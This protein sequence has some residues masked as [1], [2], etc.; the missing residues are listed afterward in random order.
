MSS[1]V[2]RFLSIVLVCLLGLAAPS[3]ADDTRSAM[4]DAMVRMMEA[5]GLFGSTGGSFSSGPPGWSN[6]MGMSGWPSGFGAMPAMPGMPGMP[7]AGSVP[8]PS[9]GGTPM[10][11]TTQ[12]GQM[13]QMMERFAPGAAPWGTGP[14]EGI[15][16]GSDDGLLIVQGERYRLYAPLSGS[17]DGD[18]RVKGDRVELSNQR[19]S[20]TQ[21]FE[22]ALDQGRLV[23]R[24]RHGQI[25][26]YRRLVLDGGR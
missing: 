6:P 19:E 20:F 17:I 4:A 2:L 25:Y 23:F 16:E 26:L 13:G 24:D 10:D 18:I 11:P 5:M 21:E 3:P 7:G 8:M 1:L 9:P 22:Y 14:L 12:M 15:W